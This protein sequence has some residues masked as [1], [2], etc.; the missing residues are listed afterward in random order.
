MCEKVTIR[1][2]EYV[3]MTQR[4]HAWLVARRVA[5]CVLAFWAAGGAWRLLRGY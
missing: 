4:D 1:P 3:A 2:I 5:Y